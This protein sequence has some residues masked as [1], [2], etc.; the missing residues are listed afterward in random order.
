MA[1]L[2]NQAAQSIA[3]A[4]APAPTAPSARWRW[5]TVVSVGNDG[6]MNVSIG[7]ATVPGIRAAQHCM[8]AQPGDRVRVMYCGTE[9]VVDAVRA[10]SEL[11]DVP[12]PSM[13]PSVKAAWLTALGLT[14]SGEA[15]TANTTNWTVSTTVARRVGNI[16]TFTCTGQCKA[17]I[18]TWQNHTYSIGTF[19]DHPAS[20]QGAT[21]VCNINSQWTPM[22]AHVDSTGTLSLRTVGTAIPANTWTWISGTFII[23]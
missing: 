4:L 14:P 15:F 9:A 23:G 12:A 13:T 20:A 1:D 8:G 18:S 17:G 7:G 5:G 19:A 11:M 21:C 2:V 6:T 10:S 16:V 22:Y 3:D